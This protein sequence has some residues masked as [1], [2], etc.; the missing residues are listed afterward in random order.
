M[1]QLPLTVD[2]IVQLHSE[3][4]SRASLRAAVTV[5]LQRPVVWEINTTTSE[6]DG[7]QW[8]LRKRDGED[9]DGV[10]YLL[11]NDY[12]VSTNPVIWARVF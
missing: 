6:D 11:P 2:Q 10:S 3:I 8:K 7:E 9:D 1:F 12:N 5:G 4:T